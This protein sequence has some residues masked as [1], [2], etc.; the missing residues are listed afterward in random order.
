MQG[1]FNYDTRGAK[2]LSG[3]VL[4]NNDEFFFPSIDPK[5]HLA[6]DCFFFFFS[7]STES[8]LHVNM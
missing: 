3:Q 4:L 5:C 6:N 7:L 2:N 8:N 1:K